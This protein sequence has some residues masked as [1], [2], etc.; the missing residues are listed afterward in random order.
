MSA[1]SR[2]PWPS[3]RSRMNQAFSAKRQASRNSG[4][5]KRSQTSRTPRRLASDTGCPPPLL[6]VIVT[7]TTGRRRARRQQV[8]ERREVDVALERVLRGRVG[9][10]A[11]TRSTAS[12]PV[13]STLA[14][15]VSKWVLFGTTLPGAADHGEEDLLG[16]P[17]L[18]DRDHVLER[19]Q[20]PHR[21]EE[22]VVRRRA[23]VRL[24]AV[25]DR[26]PL[27]PAHRAGAGVGEQVDEHVLGAHLEQVVGRAAHVLAALGARCVIRS[28]STEWIRNGSKIVRKVR[29]VHAPHRGVDRLHGERTNV[30]SLALGPVQQARPPGAGAVRSPSP[31]VGPGAFG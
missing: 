26:R 17:P 19:E 18:V 21:V 22:D 7:K 29:L 24:V 6:F 15:V 5:P 3:S 20:L 4:L 1:T 30:T 12:A 14:R 11:M 16:G 27:V 10:S 28:G 13:A 8:L 9:P 31:G 23:G 2:P 25:L